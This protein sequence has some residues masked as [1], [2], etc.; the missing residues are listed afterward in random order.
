MAAS[1]KLGKRVRTYREKLGL[2]EEELAT[3]SGLG[4]H[5]IKDIE[6]G[7]TYPPISAIIKISRALG[8]RVGTFMDDQFI[9]DPLIVKA[10]KREEETSSHRGAGGH[11]HYY[12]LGKGKTD[13]HMEPLYIKIEADKNE[14]LSSH[15]GEEFIIVISGDI[16]LIYGKQT[17]KLGPG[18]S[19]YYNSLV[20]HHLGCVSGP[21]E[22]FAVI[23]VPV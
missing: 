18:D 8:Q 2:S 17:F 16:K 19:V 23:Y 11:Y 12:P 3:N 13:R 15:E 4:L 10:D 9:G 7:K 21:A 14:E 20:P 22:I 1:D 6:D 5:L